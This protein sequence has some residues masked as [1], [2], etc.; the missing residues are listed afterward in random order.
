MCCV[1][2]VLCCVVHLCACACVL[3]VSL[4]VCVLFV[5]ACSL[6]VDCEA[7]T[8]SSQFRF[9]RFFSPYHRL[10]SYSAPPSSF[11][12]GCC[13]VTCRDM[14]ACIRVCVSVSVS[15]SVRMY[16]CGCAKPFPSLCSL[17]RLSH[18][19][20]LRSKC[21]VLRGK[22]WRLPKRVLPLQTHIM[23]IMP[24]CFG[25]GLCLC[26]FVSVCVCVCLPVC[27]SVVPSVCL[28]AWLCTRF[29]VCSLCFF[30]LM[31]VRQSLHQPIRS[32]RCCCLAL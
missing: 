10:V 29:V 16:L 7:K 6:A 13:V 22:V 20:P 32:P 1:C 28:S 27:L 2:V 9:R 19:P 17:L 4:R 24:A 25:G 12:N 15:V 11:V 31:L 18:Q 8:P 3:S 23:P 5:L 14:S 26:V 30:F 21:Q